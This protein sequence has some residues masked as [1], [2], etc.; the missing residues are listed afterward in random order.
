MISRYNRTQTLKAALA[1]LG[2]SFCLW[3]AFLFFHHTPA[4]I[5]HLYGASLS[6]AAVHGITLAGMLI[7]LIS[8]YRQW[9]EKGGTYG[10]HQSALYHHLGDE[11]AGAALVDHYAHRVTAPAYVISQVFLA[12]PLLLL[13]SATLLA[14]RIPGTAGLENNLTETLGLLRAANK[15]QSIDA[16]PDRRTEILYLARMGL[17]DFSD[18]KGSPRIKADRSDGV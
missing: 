5:A 14:S 3:L 18:N 6:L 4:F 9:R 7:V 12:G 8:G 10:Y 15:W 1:L 2:G 16:Y 17:V 13:K 11:H